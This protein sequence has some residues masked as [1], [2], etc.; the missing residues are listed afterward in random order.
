MRRV[1]KHPVLDET[2]EL[3]ERVAQLESENQKLRAEVAQKK[4]NAAEMARAAEALSAATAQAGRSMGALGASFGA[5]SANQIRAVQDRERMSRVHEALT[6][7]RHPT[8]EPA[9]RNTPVQMR[10]EPQS[11]YDIRTRCIPIRMELQFGLPRRQ[12]TV[13][14][15]VEVPE[16]MFRDEGTEISIQAVERLSRDVQDYIRNAHRTGESFGR[17]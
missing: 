7:Y 9:L 10:L 11:S 5:F 2:Q 13:V 4:A 17:F 1:R 14:A 15:S 16:F 12:A 3:R 6:E 8:H